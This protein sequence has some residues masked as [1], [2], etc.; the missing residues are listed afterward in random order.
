MRSFIAAAFFVFTMPHDA[1]TAED[2]LYLLYVNDSATGRVL[3][4]VTCVGRPGG[5]AECRVAMPWFPSGDYTVRVSASNLFGE[6]KKS[7]VVRFKVR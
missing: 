1:R 7:N 3:A 4:D 6:G 2:L 5:V